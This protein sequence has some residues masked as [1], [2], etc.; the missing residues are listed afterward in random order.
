MAPVAPLRFEHAAEPGL[1]SCIVPAFDAETYVGETIESILAQS[2]PHREVIVVDDGSTDGTLDALERFG[3]RIRV[4]Q[5]PNR[6]PAAARNRGMCASRGEFIGFLDA[7]DLWV[8]GKLELQLERFRTRPELALTGG[9]LKSFW[10]PEL[11]HERRALEDHPYHRKRA[12]LSVCSAL[13]RRELF[14]R[15]GGFDPEL[16][17]GEDTDWFMRM[18]K[19]GEEYEILD[20]LLVH[21]RQHTSNLTRRSRPSQEKVL[22]H[23]KRV[24]DRERASSVSAGSGAVAPEDGNA[25]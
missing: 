25:G 5:Q 2:Y 24:L 13:A 17:M 21:R 14:E 10:I 1:V 18:M 8:E 19:A 22:D 7:D 11:D 16:R 15:L 4:I 12:G 23:I 6:G 20:D 9:C 3:D